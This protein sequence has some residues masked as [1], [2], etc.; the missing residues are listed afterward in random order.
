LFRSGD[1]VRDSVGCCGPDERLGIGIVVVQV[2]FDGVFEVGD[3]V[4]DA[5]SDGVVGAAAAKMDAAIRS[6]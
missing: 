1:F 2:T 5:A 4:E 3:A 6:L